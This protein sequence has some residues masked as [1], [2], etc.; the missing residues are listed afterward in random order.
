MRKG[1]PY[2]Q[3]NQYYCNRGRFPLASLTLSQINPRQS[4]PEGEVVEL[5]ESIWTVGL[6]Q[7]I[8]GLADDK[9]GAE[10]VPVVRRL[11]ALQYL[12][13]KHDNLASIRPELRT[14][15]DDRAGC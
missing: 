10:I 6:I 4:V 14:P 9:G 3:A 2:D 12:A 13:K 8:A 1:L 11:R 7:S 15:G 5:A